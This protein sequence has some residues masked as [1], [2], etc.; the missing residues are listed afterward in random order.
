M[1]KLAPFSSTFPLA[2]HYFGAL[3]STLWPLILQKSNRRLLVNTYKQS[4]NHASYDHMCTQHKAGQ[5][6][7]SLDVS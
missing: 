1:R 5:A 7:V 4:S 3:N 6:K 2:A